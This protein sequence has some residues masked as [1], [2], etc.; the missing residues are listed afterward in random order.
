LRHYDL[1]VAAWTVNGL[2]GKIGDEWHD[3][4]AAMAVNCIHHR[5]PFAVADQIIDRMRSC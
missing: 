4:V 3:L 2:P 5:I 1:R